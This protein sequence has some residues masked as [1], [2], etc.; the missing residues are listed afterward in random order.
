MAKGQTKA[1]KREQKKRPR[2]KV[3]GKQV[4]KLAELKGR[5]GKKISRKKG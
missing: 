1:E 3:S 2:M 4:F 5:P